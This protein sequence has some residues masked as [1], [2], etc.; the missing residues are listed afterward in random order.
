MNVPILQAPLTVWECERCPKEDATREPRVHTRFHSCPAVGGSW[1]PMVVRGEGSRVLLREREDYIGAEQVQMID[2]RPV[3]S[4]VT[5]HADGRVDAAVYAP[6]S[7]AF[8][9]ANL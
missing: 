7:T 6:T 1:V 9:S 5:E 3:M 2:G 8:G 4:A